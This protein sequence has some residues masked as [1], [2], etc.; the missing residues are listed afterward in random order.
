MICYE[1]LLATNNVYVNR[2]NK[3]NNYLNRRN[4]NLYVNRKN[5]NNNYLNR[6]KQSTEM[7]LND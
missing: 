5:K 7:N 2:K 3:N 4:N 1:T 6:R